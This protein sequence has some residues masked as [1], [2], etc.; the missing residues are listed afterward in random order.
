MLVFTPDI[1]KITCDFGNI[2]AFS[3][4]YK[5][6]YTSV[7]KYLLQ[8]DTPKRMRSQTLQNFKKMETDGYVRID[9]KAD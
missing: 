3:K 1:P 7:R 6:P 4:H 9:Y 5:T 2:C 8:G